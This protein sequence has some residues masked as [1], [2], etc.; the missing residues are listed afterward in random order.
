LNITNFLRSEK[1]SYTLS[2]GEQ[3]LDE[4]L[5][6]NKRGFCEHFSSVSTILMR[7]NG[8][9]SRIVTGFHGGL[10]NDSGGYYQ[11]RGQDAHAWMEYWNG[12]IWKRGDPT[13][14]VAP[15]RL[16]LGSDGFLLRAELPEGMSLRDYVG[17]KQ[18][19]AWAR[20]MLAWDS[21]YNN[22]NQKFLEYDYSVQR[23]LFNFKKIRRYSGAI[24][25]GLCLLLLGF[26]TWVWKRR[27]TDPLPPLDKA[28]MKILKK[29]KDAGLERRPGEGALTLE[30]RLPRD[31]SS[32]TETSEILELYREVKYREDGTK[33]DQF[34][35]KS[36]EFRPAKIEG[37]PL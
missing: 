15:E 10:Y 2:P 21:F 1:F 34:L 19:A 13:E 9:P 29:L 27:L 32:F 24:L 28:Y 37:K 14:V 18:S 26:V 36:N 22:L 31:W 30:R 12:E 16:S 20:F 6:E 4:F 8:I 5:F 3:T 11:V 17:M 33:L 35:T 25:M 23:D 7:L